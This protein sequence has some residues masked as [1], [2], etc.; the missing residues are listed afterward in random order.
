[1]MYTNPLL[2]V[3]NTSLPKVNLNITVPVGDLWKCLNGAFVFHVTIKVHYFYIVCRIPFSQE[4]KLLQSFTE[5]YF[6]FNKLFGENWVKFKIQNLPIHLCSESLLRIWYMYCMNRSNLLTSF[7]SKLSQ[8]YTQAN[9]H[10][11][12]AKI[13]PPVRIWLRH[14]MVSLKMDQGYFCFR[15]EW[16]ELRESAPPLFFYEWSLELQGQFL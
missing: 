15:N 13:Q 9:T 8:V 2:I 6:I 7:I 11:E 16:R 3:K 4:D 10:G 1:M 12:V 5:Q 14:S